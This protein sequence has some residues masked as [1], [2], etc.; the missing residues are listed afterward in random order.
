MATPNACW[1]W[2]IAP[3]GC[4]AGLPSM[5]A[6]ISS[7]RARSNLTV[8]WYHGTA[9]SI[10]AV[11]DCRISAAERRAPNRAGMVVSTAT[12]SSVPSTA[13]TIHDAGGE[14]D[15]R[16]ATAEQAA[17]QRDSGQGTWQRGKHLRR[18]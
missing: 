6:S 1:N 10:Q 7:L 9:A 11:S 14:V 15:P 18:R 12:A 4:G 17:A 16:L 13:P 5:D 3:E 2:A 8:F